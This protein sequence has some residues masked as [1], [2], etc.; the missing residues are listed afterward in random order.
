MKTLREMM[1]LI[2][3]A[4]TVA[5]EYSADISTQDMIAY[6]RKHHD[7]NLHQD[8]LNHINTFGKF[9]LQNIPVNTIKT[10]LSGLDQTK[11]EQYK[12]MDFSKA[13][14]I[15]MGDGYILDGYHRATVAK[16]LG[17]PTIRAYV[18]IKGHQT[19]A[20]E[21]DRY[22][23]VLTLHDDSASPDETARRKIAINV[24]ANNEQ[25]AIKLATQKLIKSPQYDG[26]RIVDARATQFNTSQLNELA[27]GGGLLAE[28]VAS[29]QPDE[30]MWTVRTQA[31]EYLVKFS[32]DPEDSDNSGE[33]GMNTAFYGRDKN[34]QWTMDIT[35]V[36][37][38]ELTQII[39]T[40]ARLLAEFLK[41][42]KHLKYIGIGGKD[43]RRDRLYQRLIQQN[44]QKYFPGQ[45][46]DIVP[47]GI[48]RVIQE[49]TNEQR[50]HLDFD[51][52]YGKAFKIT[53]NNGNPKNPGFSIVTPLNGASWN[54]KERP[55]FKALVKRK[56][57]DPG[58]LG[59]HKYQQ[60]VDAISG[61]KFDP[62]KH[63]VKDITQEEELDE[64]ANPDA[65]KRIEQLVQY[66]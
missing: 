38:K 14:P 21:A 11:V 29:G 17:I 49:D 5:E 3:S 24:S 22:R 15:V 26:S 10:E 59:D 51:L 18:G 23:V 37:E 28:P 48:N 52:L 57:N 7:T 50:Q 65:V 25:S 40:V 1:D 32:F 13:P 61:N 34:G 43:P 56:L 19:V 6:L 47:G 55:E 66:K 42:H 53:D 20:E 31:N 58:F 2:E 64:V 39:A 4:Q 35:N 60:I 44:L 9:V 30:A 45:E 54:W 36:G 41:Q 62:A 12:K 27:L 46:F 16:A 63:L 8:Y 33:G